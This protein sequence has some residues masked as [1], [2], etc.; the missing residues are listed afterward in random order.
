MKL[1]I[2]IYCDA[3]DAEVYDIT[4][5][6]I[7]DDENVQ[8]KSY[9]CTVCDSLIG[10]ATNMGNLREDARA[11]MDAKRM[12]DIVNMNSVKTDA[13][14]AEAVITEAPKPT[15]KRWGMKK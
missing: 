2:P 15:A 1:K 4:I 8:S 11:R 14:K 6:V 13:I 7:D 3:C 10:K 5:D 9:R 12:E